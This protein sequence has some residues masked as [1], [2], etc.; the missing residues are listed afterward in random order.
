MDTQ[1]RRPEIQEGLEK[2]GVTGL[3]TLVR[4]KWRGKEY[5]FVPTIELTI[6]LPGERKGVHM[7]RLV[8]S[9]AE[10]IEEETAVVH[11]SLE[12]LGRT[13][14][15]KLGGKHP[16]SQ[17]VFKLETEL[18]V[19]EETPASGKKTYETHDIVVEVKRED[20]VYTK[21]LGVEVVGNTVCPHSMEYTRG[22]A[23][24]QRAVGVLEVET[25]FDNKVGLEDM[26]SCVED[27]FSSKVY[28]LL[29]T[30]DEKRVV[31]G[32]YSNPR[33]IEDVCRGMLDNAKKQFKDSVI[34]AKAVSHESIHRHDVVAE[35][36][37]KS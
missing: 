19:K 22:K 28:T 9:I 32:M 5:R 10:S 11:D 6:D 36:S 12:D 30:E 4:T 27:S 1:D 14:L 20:G 8:E 15:E 21:T 13:V 31:E 26:I 17:G 16:Y 2:V 23:H 24:M 35:A 29:K 18:V 37:C 7:S 33:F 34:H 25:S 3:R